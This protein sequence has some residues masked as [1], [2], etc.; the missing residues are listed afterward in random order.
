MVGSLWPVWENHT[1]VVQCGKRVLGRVD[2]QASLLETR[3]THRQ[4]L[5]P[6]SFYERLADHGHQIV[7]DDDFAH[8]YDPGNGRPSIPPSIMLRALLCAVHDQVS[9]DRE[10]A[11]R[12]RVDLDWKAAMGVSAE[13]EGIGATTFSLFRA[14]LLLR[15]DDRAILERT[16]KRAI[17]LGVVTGERTAIIDSSPVTGAGAVADTYTLL[18][19]LLER[20]VRIAGDALDD[21][22]RQAAAPYLSGKPAIDWHDADARKRLLGELV[23][24]A[25]L[26]CEATGGLADPPVVEA[27]G[28]LLAVIAQDVEADGQGRP[29]IRR[30]VA[31][32]RIISHFDP[33][34][35]HG[36]KSK[37][38]K[39]DGY[40]LHLVSDEDAELVLDVEIGPGNGGDGEQAA[41]ATRRI[42]DTLD[43]LSE[44]TATVTTLLADM[45]YSD[46]DVRQDV[47]HAGAQLVAKVP[48]VHNG[49]RFTKHDFTIDPDAG[50]VTC[51]AGHTTDVS[52]GCKDHKGR[53]ARR[54]RF[55]DH[56]C[57]ACPLHDQCVKGDRGRSLT[58]GPHEQRLQAARHAQA[59]DPEVIRLL[60]A[61]AK[62]ER[63]IDH[64]QDLGMRKARYRGRRKTLLQARLA[65]TVANLKRLV[66]LEAWPPSTQ[67][68]VQAA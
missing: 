37:S 30:G 7:C 68:V 8:L 63:K 36:R 55:D 58:V 23:A 47:E 31:R 9:G 46:G 26:V 65:A 13:F 57:R 42:N 22:T 44:G 11:R 25:T 38:R 49:G 51:P 18:R 64:V 1:V 41:P 14:R 27:R 48:D 53:P 59:H 12:T 35:R 28:L 61:R 19:K 17:D 3:F 24:A 60:R 10:I 52:H 50:T 34:M 45:A 21:D 5:T 43:S 29:T 67:P 2:A 20:L 15:D 32:N 56:T 66:A 4:L 40:K 39:F 54:F 6:G 33:E 16:I 62:V